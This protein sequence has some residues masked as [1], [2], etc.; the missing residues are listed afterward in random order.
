[1]NV[2]KNELKVA[3][4]CDGTLVSEDINGSISLPYGGKIKQFRPHIPHIELL[5]NHFLRGFHVTVWSQNG[6]AHALQIVRALQLEGFVHEV[7]TKMSCHVDDR[8][9]KELVVGPRIFLKE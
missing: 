5:K 6:W 9:E 8:E 1:M 3:Y 7:G 4:D 2:N